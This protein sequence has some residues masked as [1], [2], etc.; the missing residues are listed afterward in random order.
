MQKDLKL[1]QNLNPV[2]CVILI[3]FFNVLLNQFTMT[4]YVKKIISINGLK[5]EF[6]LKAQ[7]QKII[8]DFQN[9][10]YRLSTLGTL[11][12]AF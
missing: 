5:L 12:V 10:G 9:K 8:H 4:F 3:L 2:L 11:G 1:A 7:H 6:C